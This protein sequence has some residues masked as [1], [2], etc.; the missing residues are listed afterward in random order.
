MTVTARQRAGQNPA[1]TPT[2]PPLFGPDG[3]AAPRQHPPSP[4]APPPLFWAPGGGAGAHRPAGWENPG[5]P[6]AAP[7]AL[8]CIRHNPHDRY[9]RAPGELRFPRNRCFALPPQLP[10]HYVGSAFPLP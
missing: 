2:V 1:Y 7:L 5:R 4:P 10:I 3:R 6:P 9:L 8:P